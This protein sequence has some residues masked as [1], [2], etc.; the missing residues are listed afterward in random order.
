MNTIQHYNNQPTFK[1]RIALNDCTPLIKTSIKGKSCADIMFHE[2]MAVKC[3]N[4]ISIKI[5]GLYSITTRKHIGW[6]L[7]MLYKKENINLN[8]Y[9]I[10][11]AYEKG[12]YREKQIQRSGV[13]CGTAVRGNRQMGLCNG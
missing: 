4:N 1:A 6:W 3:L 7:K 5:T 9:D 11:R 10:K 13:R 12:N 8:Y 2:N